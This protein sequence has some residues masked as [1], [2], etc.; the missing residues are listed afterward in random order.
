MIIKTIAQ[1]DI[2]VKVA[3]IHWYYR[4]RSHAAEMTAGY[5][6]YLGR[7]G[8][9]P[10]AKALKQRGAGLSFTCIEMSDTE[11]PD[12]RH[13]SPEGTCWYIRHIVM[14]CVLRIRPR[15]QRFISLIGTA[16]C[17]CLSWSSRQ[18]WGWRRAGEAGH[19]R[20]RGE[21]RDAAGGERAGGRPLQC[22]RADTHAHQLGAL[23]PACFAS[24]FLPFERL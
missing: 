23:C 3:G 18:T 15:G 7:C 5:Y 12:L 2:A 1:V 11:N 24:A 22:R 4:S 20:G 17:T 6:N 14:Q 10:I 13:C 16:L 8:Y 19:P 9:T 21:W